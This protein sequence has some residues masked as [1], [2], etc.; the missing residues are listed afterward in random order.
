VALLLAALAGKPKG[1]PIEIMKLTS[2]SVRFYI[3]DDPAGGK[4]SK[5]GFAV[6]SFSRETKGAY[7]DLMDISPEQ[8]RIY[9]SDD[10]SKSS[11]GGFAVGSF[12]RETKAEN[13]E[14]FNISNASLADEILDEARIL[15]Y[16]KKEA[17]LA[18]R[19]L[20]PHADS[21]G[22]NAFATGYH[23]MAKGNYSQAFGYQ[24]KARGN[25]STSIGNNSV[26]AGNNS[27]ALGD[28]A[29]AGQNNA[30]A[31]GGGAKATGIGSYAIGSA[32]IDTVTL[33]PTGNFTTASGNYSFAIGLGAEST[34]D[35]GISIGNKSRAYGKG[36]TAIGNWAKAEGAQSVAIG[37]NAIA[38]GN[39]AFSYRGKAS[40]P[41]A[42]AIGGTI[43][44]TEASGSGA[45]AIGSGEFKTNPF[46]N[47]PTI[48]YTRATGLRSIS[49]GSGTRATGDYATAMGQ[50][51]EAQSYNSFVIGRYNIVSGNQTTWVASDPIFVIGNGTSTVHSNALTVLKNGNIGIGTAAPTRKLEVDGT[52]KIGANG[53][54]INNIIRASI[55]RAFMSAVPAGTASVQ[56]FTIANAEVGA[57]VSVSPRN[58]LPDGLIISYARVSAAG[59]VEVKFFNATSSSISVAMSYYDFTIIN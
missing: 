32:E 9:I 50:T 15:W 37:D 13:T 8:A 59:T 10:G 21:V 53:T 4:S 44:M 47:P 14:I 58:A 51:T 20:I 36:S 35:L 46:P 34:A 43:L 16:P 48:T 31:F 6:G 1:E 26:S 38:S 3:P 30:Y 27:F 23:S 12:S 25:N 52:A 22:L 49:I 42:I 19:V 39:Y 17:F 7:F 40:G 2:D 45:I 56:T 41:Y 11:K 5:G 33:V 18:G 28:G 24:A 55:L 54:T 29:I 57:T